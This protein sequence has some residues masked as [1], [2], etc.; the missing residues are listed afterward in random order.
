M[1]ARREEPL[2]SWVDHFLRDPHLF[3]ADVS[4]DSA[5]TALVETTLFSTFGKI[6]IVVNNAGLHHRGRF[7]ANETMNL[8]KMIDVNLRALWS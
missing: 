4:D 2:A 7:D 8:A 3:P 1:V 5:M 6:D